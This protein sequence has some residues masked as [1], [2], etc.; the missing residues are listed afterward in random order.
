M[1][2]VK[3]SVKILFSFQKVQFS[4]RA[5]VKQNTTTDA[6]IA[7]ARNALKNFDHPHHYF[8]GRSADN[9]DSDGDKTAQWS[10]WSFDEVQ[11]LAK[12]KTYYSV[13]M[14][15]TSLK[16]GT[17]NQNSKTITMGCT[18]PA[19]KRDHFKWCKE[20]LFKTLALKQD[21]NDQ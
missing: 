4:I 11:K 17:K 6:I 16:P 13:T 2:S 7:R 15:L 20:C 12:Y 18:C 9:Y 5:L 10:I 8:F 21:Q 1:L 19:K 14:R 3:L